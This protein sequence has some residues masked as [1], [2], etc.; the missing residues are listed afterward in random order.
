MSFEDFYF[1]EKEVFEKLSILNLQRFITKDLMVSEEQILS[2][3][4]IRT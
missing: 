3:A 4:Q 2:C 1:I